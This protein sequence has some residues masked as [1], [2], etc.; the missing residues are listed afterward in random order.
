MK[1][2]RSFAILFLFLATSAHADGDTSRSIL[3]VAGLHAPAQVV[4]DVDGMPHMYAWDEHDALFVQ[5]WVQAEDRLFQLDVLRRTASGTLAEL[6]GPAA[7]PSDVELRYHRPA[8][9]RQSGRW[10]LI[11]RPRAPACRPMPMA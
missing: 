11:R 8:P 5:G 9:R 4:R 6:L 10:R 2:L 3:A 7:L 1:T